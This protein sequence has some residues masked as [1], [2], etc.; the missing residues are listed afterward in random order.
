MDDFIEKMEHKGKREQIIDCIKRARVWC[1]ETT[2]ILDAE[3]FIEWDKTM[4]GS[5]LLDYD[6]EKNYRRGLIWQ[7]QLYLSTYTRVAIKYPGQRA[8]T[9]ATYF[10]TKDAGYQRFDD[11]SEENLQDLVSTFQA[12][13][14][15]KAARLR[16]YMSRGKLQSFALEA[17]KQADR[18]YR[19][20]RRSTH[21]AA[22][23]V[24][25]AIKKANG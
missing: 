24:N 5:A 14:R 6:Q 15:N 9:V 16:E 22:K 21:G 20:A 3:A 19:K 10:S 8:F 7:A 17:I 2:R 12:M 13:I 23:T 11:L 25:G 1:N 4:N 18:D